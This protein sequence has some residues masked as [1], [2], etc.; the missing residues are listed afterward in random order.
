MNTFIVYYELR[1]IKVNE[2]FIP[3]LF[4]IAMKLVVLIHYHFIKP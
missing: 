1:Q 2:E 3:I 4:Q